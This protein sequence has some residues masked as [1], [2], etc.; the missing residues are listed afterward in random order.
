M[1]RPSWSDEE[2]TALAAIAPRDRKALA[3]FRQKF[4][5][6]SPSAIREKLAV[7]RRRNQALD[8][9]HAPKD[10]RLKPRPARLWTSD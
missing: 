6:R 7:L 3:A 10:L 9:T 4:P 5:G 8:V 1:P 2:L